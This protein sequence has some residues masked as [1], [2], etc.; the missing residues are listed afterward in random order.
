MAVIGTDAYSTAA[1]DAAAD[2]A[3]LIEIIPQDRLEIRS[4]CVS[5]LSCDFSGLISCLSDASVADCD[6]LLAECVSVRDSL[7]TDRAL[8]VC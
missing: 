8:G 6:A 4:R 2:C 3:A 1:V 7:L 5:G